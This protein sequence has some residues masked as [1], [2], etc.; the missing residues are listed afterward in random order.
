M[1]ETKDQ[2]DNLFIAGG[3]GANIPLKTGSVDLVISFETSSHHGQGQAMMAEIARVLRPGGD[4]I[5]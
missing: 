1:L 5:I 2:R 4:F 3:T